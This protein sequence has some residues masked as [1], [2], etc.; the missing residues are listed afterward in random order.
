VEACSSLE[1]AAKSGANP[2]MAGVIAMNSR[3]RGW[4]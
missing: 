1:R 3:Q 2:T 4:E